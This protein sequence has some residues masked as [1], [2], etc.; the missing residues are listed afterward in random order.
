AGYGPASGSATS[1]GAGGAGSAVC[2]PSSP[3]S[4]S[5]CSFSV[6]SRLR[7][8]GHMSERA[9]ADLEQIA[10]E[11]LR[12]HRVVAALALAALGERGKRAEDLCAVDGERRRVAVPREVERVTFARVR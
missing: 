2:E 4:R 7:R 3:A 8:N 9:R 10:V 11:P 1:G 6:S 12:V 5:S